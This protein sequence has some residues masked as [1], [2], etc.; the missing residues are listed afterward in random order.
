M[1]KSCGTLSPILDDPRQASTVQLDVKGLEESLGHDVTVRTSPPQTTLSTPHCFIRKQSNSSQQRVEHTNVAW[2]DGKKDVMH[3]HSHT[4]VLNTTWINRKKYIN[5]LMYPWESWSQCSLLWWW[6]APG[7]SCC[8]SP[9]GRSR[10]W[11]VRLGLNPQAQ[12]T[13]QSHE[14]AMPAWEVEQYPLNASLFIL[15]VTLF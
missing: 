11:P 6:L 7:G 13:Y 10:S 3:H 8:C 5:L 4:P 2:R 15:K 14:S 9:G 1:I 12:W